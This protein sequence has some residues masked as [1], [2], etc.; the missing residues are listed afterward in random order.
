MVVLGLNR[1]EIIKKSSRNRESEDLSCHHR[2]DCHGTLKI[3]IHTHLKNVAGYLSRQVVFR[4]DVSL[5][6]S[7]R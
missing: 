4:S 5:F 6:S 3:R 1:R 2:V 7:E